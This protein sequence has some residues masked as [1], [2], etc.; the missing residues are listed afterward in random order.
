MPVLTYYVPNN[1]YPVIVIG[2]DDD[3][4]L[5]GT[6]LNDAIDGRRG[7][8]QISGVGGHDAIS[9]NE[10]RDRINGD[11]GYDFLIGHQGDDTI[12]GGS[13]NDVIVGVDPTSDFGTYEQDRLRGD[14]GADTFVLGD[15]NHVYYVD[16]DPISPGEYNYGLIV[17]FTVGEDTIELN[18]TP[19]NYY[20]AS[21]A[22][23][24]TP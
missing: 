16:D 24:P 14:E 3:D 2:T 10:G 15:K 6:Y 5:T 22:I 7:N 19:E 12:S 4:S 18:G 20:L 8:D 13:G 11:G 21:S 23:H 1:I 17:D 9:G